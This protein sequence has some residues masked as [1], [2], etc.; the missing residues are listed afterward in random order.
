MGGRT[1][2]DP[3]SYLPKCFFS[4]TQ[5]TLPLEDREAKLSTDVSTEISLDSK[6][7]NFISAWVPCAKKIRLEQAYVNWT[8]EKNFRS[9]K[10]KKVS[11]GCFL[12]FSVGGTF[13]SNLSFISNFHESCRRNNSNRYF[14]RFPVCCLV[15][16]FVCDFG[17]RS[18][19]IGV[20]ACVWER[21]SCVWWRLPVGERRVLRCVCV[22]VFKERAREL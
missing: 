7:L 8:C 5:I 4:N 14:R 19:C 17:G 2:E 22:C 10:P 3:C 6:S 20:S 16:L 11:G 13:F 1:T 12:L 9:M 21:E 18:E 15:C